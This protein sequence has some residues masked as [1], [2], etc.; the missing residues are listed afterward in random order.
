MMNT[1]KDPRNGSEGIKSGLGV[2]S[3]L[4]DR[5]SPLVPQ[6]GTAVLLSMTHEVSAGPI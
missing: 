5:R 6:P 1:C 4:G 3:G 2:H